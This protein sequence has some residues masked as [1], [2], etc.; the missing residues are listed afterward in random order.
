MEATVDRPLVYDFNIIFWATPMLWF[1]DW[2]DL[3]VSGEFALVDYG[4]DGILQ[5]SVPRFWLASVLN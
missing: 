3:C 5:E 1:R 4:G 2:V